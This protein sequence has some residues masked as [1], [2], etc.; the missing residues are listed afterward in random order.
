MDASWGWP[1]GAYP[2][3]I[4]IRSIAISLFRCYSRDS[5]ALL[6]SWWRWQPHSGGDWYRTHKNGRM[7]RIKYEEAQ[8]E[9]PGPSWG[10]C[11]SET[12]WQTGHQGLCCYCEQ[13]QEPVAVAVAD[14]V[15]WDDQFP[16]QTSPV[17]L[18]NWEKNVQKKN[19][20]RIKI[21]C[22][23]LVSTKQCTAKMKIN[24]MKML[25]FRLG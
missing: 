1:P 5:S 11:V 25:S 9:H 20:I 23:H 19:L 10:L 22:S 8:R 7:K 12:S 16:A 6:L 14:I 13:E 21:S 3:R 15:I 24:E 2:E 17:E 18:Q 4:K